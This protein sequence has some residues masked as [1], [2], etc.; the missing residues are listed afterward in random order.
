MA[1]KK[2]LVA[3]DSLTI[4]KVIKLA[5]SN[6][7]YTIQAVS[8]GNDAMEQ[9]SV[10]RPDVVLIDVSLPSQSAF[11]IKRTI[12]EHPDLQD[13][14]F[15]LMSSAFEKV[16]EP[17]AEEVGFHG[18]LT[19]PFDPAHLRQVLQ[20]VLTGSTAPD[21]GPTPPPRTM[22]PLPSDEDEH[23]RPD[24][25]REIR[26][27]FD[28]QRNAPAK[29]TKPETKEET[30]EIRRPPQPIFLEDSPAEEK[31]SLSPPDLSHLDSS[32]SPPPHD[33]LW[34]E[35][36]GPPAPPAIGG[37]EELES[38]YSSSQPGNE[39]FGSLDFKSE[40]NDIKQLTEST[41]RMSGLGEFEWKVNEPNL[42][43]IPNF[44]D[45][46]GSSFQ[47]AP[48]AHVPTHPNAQTSTPTNF[49][50]QVKRQMEE[51]IEKLIQRML[52]EVA[53]RMI[54]EEIHRLLSNPPG[55]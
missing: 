55:S 2:L 42:K 53:E 48:P 54:K 5:L 51:T 14:K 19:K 7:G 15:V 18:R 45:D 33:S 36:Q 40:D 12:N 28:L 8:D 9:I 43:P 52:P 41:I 35:S 38:S 47:V 26:R 22:P 50:E 24:A 34:E 39:N 1:G 23:M 27:P 49:D 37:E 31:I 32:F 17:Q 25:T 20:H 46:G 29:E 4:Q 16:D 11:E 10:F 44:A 3:D 21:T 30:K 6:E 13:V